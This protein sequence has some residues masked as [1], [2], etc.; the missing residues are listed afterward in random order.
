MVADIDTSALID[1]L[2]A[3][4]LADAPGSLTDA[5]AAAALALLDRIVPDL[6]HVELERNPVRFERNRSFRRSWRI[7]LA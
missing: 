6:H 4:A 2:Q 7:G 5:Q 3:F 1:K